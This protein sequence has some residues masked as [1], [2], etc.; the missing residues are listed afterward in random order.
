VAIKITINEIKKSN[1]LK[2]IIQITFTLIIISVFTTT[3]IFAIDFWG[4]TGHRVVG[5]IAT[6]YLKPSTK[7]KIKKLLDGQSLAYVSTFA[8]D[9]KS[10]SR[11]K[12]FE[13]WHYI[14]MPMDAE[15][16][17]EKRNE[18]GDLVSAIDYC[19][20]I[21]T[22]DNN[23]K[24]D[25]AFYLKLLVHFI[26]DLHQPMHVGLEEDRGGND[27]KVYWFRKDSNLHRVWD[28]DMIDGHKMSYS[29]LAQNRY[30]FSKKE[31]KT[32]KQG[33]VIDWVNEVH[34]V[35]AKVYESAKPGDYLSYRYSYDY[36]SIA[37]MQL[38]KAG[39]RLAQVLNDML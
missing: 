17:P 14:N 27:F 11:Y 2:T 22:N 24:D 1:P 26:G 18:K 3:S 32:I 28:S 8:D 34:Q 5:E 31:I 4:S 37:E 6:D 7:R 33:T 19:I 29:E 35:T 13:T 9:I 36:F 15:Y 25:R 20:S 38:H 10:D 39:I 21:I 16:N 30:Y 12:K 23:S